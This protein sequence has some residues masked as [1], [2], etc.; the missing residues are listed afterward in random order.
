MSI[1]D[2]AACGPEKLSKLSKA[3][4]RNNGSALPILPDD[5]IGARERQQLKRP[6][7][8]VSAAFGEFPL[9]CWRILQ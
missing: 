9:A 2:H 7:G 6:N 3:A 5:D 4:Q 1:N 8:L